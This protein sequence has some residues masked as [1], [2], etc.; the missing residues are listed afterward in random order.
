ME[1]KG[2]PDGAGLESQ[3]PGEELGESRPRQR[4]PSGLFT[5][6]S[7]PGKRRGSIARGCWVNLGML[8]EGILEWGG[9]ASIE[10]EVITESRRGCGPGAKA[11]DL[12]Y[13][14]FIS[15]LRNRCPVS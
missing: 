8:K 11:I 10:T 1:D 9:T 5:L 6:P 4:S 15:V 13:L 3:W 2:I 14:L 12:Q 7:F